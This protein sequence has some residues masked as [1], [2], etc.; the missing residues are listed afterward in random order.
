MSA[1]FHVIL[2]R[3]S[4]HRSAPSNRLLQQL[5]KHGG[6][7][8][9]SKCNPT[10]SRQLQQQQYVHSSSFAPSR[11][12]PSC[13]RKRSERTI[14]FFMLA[15]V[16]TGVSRVA[17]P[18]GARLFS[19]ARPMTRFVQ[20]PF[21]KSKVKPSHSTPH[22]QLELTHMCGCAWLQDGRSPRLGQRL[23]PRWQD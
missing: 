20:Y 23:W 14:S 1:D 6:Q 16:S 22:Y 4:L 19:D 3:V 8:Q 21:D 9:R 12:F 7:L 5:G 18:L 15:R 13:I 2:N 11:S 17:K 10:Q